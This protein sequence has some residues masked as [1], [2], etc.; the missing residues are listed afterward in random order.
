MKAPQEAPTDLQPYTDPDPSTVGEIPDGEP[1]FADVVTHRDNGK[2]ALIPVNVAIFVGLPL[3][4]LLLVPAWGLYHGY[5]AT[6]WWM[7]LLFLYLNGL[8]I[9]AG[10][11]RLWSHNAYKAHPV[12]RVF[13]A[14]WGAGALQNSILVW[15]SD[16]RRHHRHVDDNAADPY[17]AGRGLWFSHM[18]WMLREYQTNEED[19]SNAPD[20]QRDPVVMWQHRHY[21]AITVAMNVVLP[22]LV[23]WW[24]GDVIGGLLLVGLLRLIVNHHV[25]FFINSLAH[26][27]GSQPYTDTNSARDNG[28]LAF[29]TYGEGY[30]N[31]H[32]IFQ[33]DYR[34]GIRWYQWDPTKWLIN[35]C[36]WLGLASHLNRVP[37]FR[38]QQSILAMQFKRAEAQ[39]ERSDS[40]QPLR[41]KL[42]QE[43]QLFTE[44]LNRWKALQ[45][46]RYERQVGV[47]EGALAEKKARLISK[48]EQAALRTSLRELEYSL[49]MQRKRLELLMMQL[50]AV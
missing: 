12:L 32:H 49:K 7:A 16:H 9:T 31:F 25:T 8:S 22:L 15:G 48:W 46:A 39:L 26:Y 29:L 40:P 41:E 47:L 28:F 10:Y 45:S 6:L 5:S 14:L 21:V 24:A 3:L 17:S 36:S 2:P 50:Q 11:H 18:G 23:G 20:L 4:A 13:F 43:Y 19:F 34:N 27:W 42:E 33:S 30:H 44:A 37:A 35:L 38:I 1:A